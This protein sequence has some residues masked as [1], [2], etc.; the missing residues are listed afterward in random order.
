MDANT[1]V[2]LGH[3]DGRFQ[4]GAVILPTAA[5]AKEVEVVHL[6]VWNHTWKFPYMAPLVL[7]ESGLVPISGPAGVLGFLVPQT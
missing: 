3:R 6:I 4:T 1:N 7:G 2:G 5:V